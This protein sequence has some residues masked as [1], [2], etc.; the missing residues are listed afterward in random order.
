MYN[1]FKN[2]YYVVIL[3]NLPNKSSKRKSGMKWAPMKP[4]I[5]ILWGSE[6]LYEKLSFD[7]FWAIFKD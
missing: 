1:L 5:T 3:H 2:L 7:L 4:K 6:V